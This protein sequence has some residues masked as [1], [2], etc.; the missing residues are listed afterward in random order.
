MLRGRVKEAPRR[1]IVRRPHPVGGYGVTPLCPDG[2]GH[3]YPW[4]GRLPWFCPHIAHSGNGK[5]F[6][7]EEVA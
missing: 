4:D 1:V 7:E 2:H 6:S 5:F 3:L